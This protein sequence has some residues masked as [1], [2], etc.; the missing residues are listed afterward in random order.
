MSGKIYFL[1]DKRGGIK[2]GFSKAVDVRIKQLQSGIGEA[3]ELIGTIDGDFQGEAFL[4]AHL[5]NH[6]LRLEWFRDC[7]EVRECI[8][9]ALSG[10]LGAL[11]FVPKERAAEDEEPYSLQRARALVDIILHW[12]RSDKG[13]TIG[14]RLAHLSLEASID[15]GILNTLRYRA[16]KDIMAHDFD[17][18]LEAAVKVLDGAEQRVARDRKFVSRLIER[19]KRHRENT[20][21]SDEILRDAQYH[22]ALFRAECERR[23]LSYEDMMAE[24]QKSMDATG[25]SDEDCRARLD[26]AL[27]DEFD[28]DMA[29]LHEGPEDA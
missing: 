16:A 29:V 14:K 26:Q 17:S 24:V 19:A 5:S 12:Y 25:W 7:Q 3:L 20:Q 22:R 13:E 8:D 27:K 2:I 23:G 18:L 21:R 10:G 4:H 11:G 28:G 1:S 6:R 9:A 15:R